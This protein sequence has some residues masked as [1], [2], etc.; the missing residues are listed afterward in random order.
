MRNKNMS[1]DDFYS[2]IRENA[3][4]TF[5]ALLK[6]RL[7]FFKCGQL[8]NKAKLQL[9]QSFK[10]LQKRLINDKVLSLRQ[11]QRFMKLSSS[12]RIGK[13][14]MRLPPF[15]T[16][17]DWLDSLPE[18]EFKKIEDKI[19]RKVE[20]KELLQILDLPKKDKN[21]SNKDISLRNEIVSVLINE[22]KIK[23]ENHEDL[24][25]FISSLKLLVQKYSFLGVYEKNYLKQTYEYLSNKSLPKKEKEYKFS[26][27]FNSKKIINI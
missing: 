25:K 11:Q 8:L 5:E 24:K 16:F 12:P 19:N 15:W 4:I 21:K 1:V 2:R 17:A 22:T 26:K 9:K 27:S 13:Y 18:H 14:I 23:K 20:K 3:E 7:G 6:E 10:Q